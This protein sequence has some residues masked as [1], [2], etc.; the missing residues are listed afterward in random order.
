MPRKPGPRQVSL[1]F[2]ASD[3]D[4]AAPQPAPPTVGPSD[5]DTP[6][7]AQRGRPRKWASEAERKR[8]YRER[9]AADLAEPDRLRQELR[10]ARRRLAGRDAELAR[11]RRQL[12]LASRQMAR[13]DADATQAAATRETL[14]QQVEY[15]RTRAVRAENLADERRDE[16]DG[17]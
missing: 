3:G 9:L 1:P 5:D 4:D 2:D 12:D 10:N 11:L 15:F 16:Q 17:R 13:L 14:E 7:P 8:A 6:T